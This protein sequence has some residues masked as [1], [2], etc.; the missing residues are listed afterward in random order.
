[1]CHFTYGEF[2]L[3]QK[4][5]MEYGTSTKPLLLPELF[6]SLSA[7]TLEA[8]GLGI[9]SIYCTMVVTRAV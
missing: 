8:G 2:D 1:M 7:I 6:L 3:P 5:E 4:V 9:S